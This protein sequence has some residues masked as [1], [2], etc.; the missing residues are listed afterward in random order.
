MAFVSGL[1][2]KCPVCSG[3]RLSV[4]AESLDQYEGNYVGEQRC[5]D[6]DA[7]MLYSRR[8]NKGEAGDMTRRRGK[9]KAPKDD[10]AATE[11]VA[12]HRVNVIP[13]NGAPSTSAAVAPEKVNAG[14]AMRQAA[15]ELGDV[16]VDNDLAPAQMRELGEMYE[17]IA[18]RRAAFNVKADL[19][20]DAK[21]AL[22]TAE[23]ALLERVR[24]YTH[25]PAMPLFDKVEAE[26]DH[27]AMLD[28]AEN[29]GMV[30]PPAPVTEAAEAFV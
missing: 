27:A 28:A 29:E 4:V 24:M 6:C 18:R 12:S 26:T 5:D 25:K 8:P 2:V 16:A 19:A 30:A 23:T 15:A 10:G 20:K 9:G 14:E 17:D 1:W 13:S 7:R 21:K 22:E 3:E 11:P